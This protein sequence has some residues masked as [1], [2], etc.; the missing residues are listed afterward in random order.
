MPIIK[1]VPVSFVSTQILT[2]GWQHATH[3]LCNFFVI[4]KMGHVTVLVQDALQ[5][6]GQDLEVCVCV[7]ECE[8]VNAW[9]GPGVVCVC[10][11]ACA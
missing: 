10:V 1:G 11:C 9:P 7:C 4:V 3:H 8:C 6:H 5:R 2:L